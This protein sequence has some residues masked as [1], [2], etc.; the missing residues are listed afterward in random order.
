MKSPALRVLLLARS[1]GEWWQQLVAS[2]EEQAAA[3]LQTTLPVTLG[4]VHAP[5][6]AQEVFADALTAFTD[7]LGVSRPAATLT[8]ADPD[9]MV[10]VVMR[11]PCSP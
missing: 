10:L 1:A 7:E 8:L 4:P 6:S 9:P 5:G 2:A 3:L 11:R